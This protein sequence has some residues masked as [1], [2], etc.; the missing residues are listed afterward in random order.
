MSRKPI[1]ILFAAALICAV[2]AAGMA[3][4]D[5]RGCPGYECYRPA[6]PMPKLTEEQRAQIAALREEHLAAITPLRDQLREKKMTLDVLARNPNTQPNELRALAEDI[7]K[8]HV[9]LRTVNNDFCA[10]MQKQNLPCEALAPH[11]GYCPG[12]LCP[13]AAR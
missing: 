7:S 8:L 9:Q 2:P 6:P 4:P 13:S 5:F 10:K 11:K 1:A 3:K 12:V